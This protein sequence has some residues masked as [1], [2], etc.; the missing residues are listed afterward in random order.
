MTIQDTSWASAQGGTTHPGLVGQ[1]FF[2]TN[3]HQLD[4]QDTAVLGRLTQAYQMHLLARRIELTCVGHADRRGDAAANLR[5][6][7]RRA[8]AIQQYLRQQLRSFRLFSCQRAISCGEEN[9]AQGQPSQARMAE[10]RRVDLFSNFIP[11]RRVVLPPLRVTVAPP[12][13]RCIYRFYASTTQLSGGA[14]D[15]TSGGTGGNLSNAW[16]DSLLQALQG[17]LL[18]SGPTPSLGNEQQ[19]RRQFASRSATHRVNRIRIERQELYS[20]PRYT[21]PSILAT[22]SHV[23][24]EWGVATEN[25]ELITSRTYRDGLTQRSQSS[26]RTQRVA[27]SNVAGNPFFFPP[28][29]PQ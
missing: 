1:I 29:Q 3:S 26:T 24:Y 27:R 11:Q 5:L 10:D 14:N 28:D 12:V 25:I 4:T 8:E 18:S 9:A 23:R 16:F 6:G 13:N 15:I 21:G 7:Q 17:G 22:S 19:N 20:P 2:A